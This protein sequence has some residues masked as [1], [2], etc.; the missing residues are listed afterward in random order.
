MIMTSFIHDVSEAGRAAQNFVF[1]P[2]ARSCAPAA[3][4]LE[5][6][7]CG[8]ERQASSGRGRRPD[9]TKIAVVP[10]TIAPAA[11]MSRPL[12]S[13]LEAKRFDF[14]FFIN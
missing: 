6:Q 12:L 2:Q 7:E 3:R 13:M 1:T 8:R 11:R 10:I 5:G 9:Q 14:S 4:G